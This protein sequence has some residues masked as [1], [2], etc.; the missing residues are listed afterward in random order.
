[1]MTTCALGMTAPEESFTV[2]VSVPPATCAYAWQ[3]PQI[4]IAAI[5]SIQTPELHFS[6][7][8]RSGIVILLN[9]RRT[10]TFP[11]PTDL[12]TPPEIYLGNLVRL[13][14]YAGLVTFDRKTC[15]VKSARGSGPILCCR[16]SR[17]D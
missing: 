2:P 8:S 12:H 5:T 15:Q 11:K 6:P 4:L 3:V 17:R 7:N 10:D 1:M 16:E 13:T 14:R 9:H